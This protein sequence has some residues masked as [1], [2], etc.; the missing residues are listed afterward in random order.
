MVKIRGINK[1]FLFNIFFMFEVLDE[2]LLYSV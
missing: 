2:S 1:A